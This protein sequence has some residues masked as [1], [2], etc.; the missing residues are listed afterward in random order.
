MKE[1]LNVQE[2]TYVLTTQAD[3][4][5]TWTAQTTLTSMDAVRTHGIRFSP[6]FENST[7]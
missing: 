2:R 1:N 6:N 4:T 7:L 3:A 5:A